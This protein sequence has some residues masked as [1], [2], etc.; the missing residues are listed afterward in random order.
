MVMVTVALPV[1]WGKPA[2]NW[3]GVAATDGM[4]LLT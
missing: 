2:G 4:G 3:A 1:N